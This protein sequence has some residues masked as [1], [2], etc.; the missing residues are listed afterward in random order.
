MRL[1]TEAVEPTYSQDKIS[2]L[3]EQTARV[4]VLHFGFVAA[5]NGDMPRADLL[6]SLLTA[7]E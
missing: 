7:F 5:T 6:A 4:T 1:N 3:I 2:M